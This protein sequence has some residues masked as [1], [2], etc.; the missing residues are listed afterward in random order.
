MSSRTNDDRDHR[1]Q[2]E[3]ECQQQHHL[4]V[5]YSRVDSKTDGAEPLA[6]AME[7]WGPALYVFENIGLLF[8]TTSPVPQIPGLVIPLPV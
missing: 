7:A 2:S 1:E 6:A 3:R 4:S 5:E 8:E